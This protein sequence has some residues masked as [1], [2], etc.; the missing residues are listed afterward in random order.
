MFIYCTSLLKKVYF[1]IYIFFLGC[2]DGLHSLR[3][4][5][6]LEYDGDV[7]PPRGHAPG[8]QVARAAAGRVLLLRGAHLAHGALLA[9]ASVLRRADHLKPAVCLAPL[10]LPDTTVPHIVTVSIL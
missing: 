9:L 8:V 5:I 10:Q 3:G 4:P 2:A 6:A 1:F 7:S